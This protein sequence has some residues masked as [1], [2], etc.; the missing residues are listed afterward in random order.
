MSVNDIH[1]DPVCTGFLGLSNL[2]AEPAE[3]GSEY[4]RGQLN[5]SH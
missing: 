1:M 5:R 2:F 4:R 3:V